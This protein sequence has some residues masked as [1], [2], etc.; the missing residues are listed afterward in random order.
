MASK[1][2][3]QVSRI[4]LIRKLKEAKARIEKEG[5]VYEVEKL[6]IDKEVMAE[7]A[8]VEAWKKKAIK[9]AIASLSIEHFQVREHRYSQE[10]VIAIERTF[11]P[12]E[13]GVEP[14]SNK[15][16]EYPEAPY[17]YHN[18]DSIR[19]TI[20]LLEIGTDSSV[21]ASLYDSVIRYIY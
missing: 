5:K 1:N 17:G 3:I 18:L 20:S 21:P 14:Y 16:W 12:K 2:Q 11:D 19:N 4:D 15:E 6:K 7:K 9:A 8:K 13:L 10:I